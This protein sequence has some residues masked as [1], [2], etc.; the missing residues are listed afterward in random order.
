MTPTAPAPVPTPAPPPTPPPSEPEAPAAARYRVVFDST[1]TAATHPQDAPG[2]PHFSPPIG[3]THNA[4]V[5]FWRDGALASDGIRLM[6]E[7]GR[8]SPLDDEIRAA[9]AAGKAQHL[10][11]GVGFSSPKTV[12]LDF[13]VSRD[14]PLVTM[15]TMVAPSPDWFAG[16]SGLPL[17]ENGAWVQERVVQVIPW[18]AG[19][20]S[21]AS[22]MSSDLPTMPRQPIARISTA[23]FAVGGVVA[24][25][26]TF[27]F[28]RIGSS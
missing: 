22:F 24:P 7:Q 9:I 5:A 28:T 16:V 25:L 11:V 15:V 4:S 10:F 19:T 21:G 2:N 1:W 17:F 23:P 14:Y 8:T 3:A 26:G 27:R 12:S 18:D 13:D 6:A 20:D